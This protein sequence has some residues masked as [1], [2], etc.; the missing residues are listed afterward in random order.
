MALAIEKIRTNPKMLFVGIKKAYEDYALHIFDFLYLPG[1]VYVRMLLY[2]LTILSL[3]R[4]IKNIRDPLSSA[5]ILMNFGILAS[6]PFTPPIDDGIRAMTA[7]MPTVGLTAAYIF[8]RKQHEIDA[9]CSKAYNIADYAGIA[10]VV[11]TLVCVVGPIWVK[12]IAKPPDISHGE[13]QD[14]YEF[15]TIDV[16]K[17]SFVSIVGNDSV[18]RSMVPTVRHADYISAM[19]GK[20]AQYPEFWAAL[21]DVE[22]GQS[23]ILGLNLDDFRIKSIGYPVWMI[24]QTA[25]VTN[26]NGIN[27]FCARPTT[28]ALLKNYRVYYDHSVD[29]KIPGEVIRR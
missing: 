29:V 13:C 16:R 15:I 27:Q 10:G 4:M 6:I 17:G 14:G 5:L 25:A 1:T 19:K 7:T 18:D 8:G 3:L 12:T 26:R 2:A 9:S 22:A 21:N 11:L 20:E 23:I 28:N 24:T